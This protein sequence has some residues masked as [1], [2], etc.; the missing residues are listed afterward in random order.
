MWVFL[1]LTVLVGALLL[2]SFT[3]TEV[4][5]RLATVKRGELISTLP[6]NGKV[7]PVQNFAAFSPRAGTVKGVYVHN[8]EK[9]PAG[10]LLLILDDSEAKT[11]VSAALAAV[12]G[13]QAQLQALRHGGTRPEQIILSG[14]IGKAKAERDQAAANLATLERLQKQGAASASEVD[15]ARRTL[16]A[17]NAGLQVFGQQQSQNFAPI[18]LQHAQANLANAQ[19]AYASAL[20]VLQKEDV[21]APFAGTV[22]SVLVHSSDFVQ[23]G[24]KLLQMANLNRTR[25]R[26]Y[27]DEPEI[28]KLVVGEPVK[29]VWEAKLHH[30]WTG[31][32]VRTPTTIVTYGTRN[33]GE[34]LISV[35]NSDG[36]LLPNTN[37]T[38]TVTLKDVPNALIV[39]REALR[40]G[41]SGDYV[42]RVVDNHLK[43]VPV[44]IGE[45]NLTEVQILSGLA[46]GDIVALSAI[47]GSTL[48]S[49]LAVRR[50]D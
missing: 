30:T 25:V 3:H 9:V 17:D 2:R 11:Q 29:I 48:R 28:G 22:Y 24:D 45:L 10:K 23:A 31:H 43:H 21:R 49:G 8:G 44:K 38:I 33:V 26:A 47:D 39:P 13:A 40:V 50:A 14:N 34:A 19:A 32:V 6:T 4:Q 7:E 5:V 16:A 35:D 15:A 12:R 18:D 41:D 1:A 27:F 36:T 20:D 42:Y 37:V 46:E